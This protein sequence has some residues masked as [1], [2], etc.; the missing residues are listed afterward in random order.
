MNHN[1]KQHNLNHCHR[2]QGRQ[3]MEPSEQQQ[4]Q[5]ASASSSATGALPLSQDMVIDRLRAMLYQESKGYEYETYFPDPSLHHH[6]QQQQQQWNP[7]NQEWR[8]KICQWTYNVVDTYD[9]PREIVAL[10]LNYF[11]RFLATRGNQ[12]NGTLALLVSLTTLHIAMKVHS[13]T[14]TFKLQKLAELSR[15]Q[16]GPRHI[17]QMEWQIMSALKFKLHPPTLFAF[18]SYYMMLFPQQ[19]QQQ[20]QQDFYHHHPYE[21][22]VIPRHAVRKELFEVAIYMAELSV[23][24]SFFV[25]YPTSLVA[26]AALANVMEDMPPSKLPPSCKQGFWDLVSVNVGLEQHP[27]YGRSHGRT[28]LLQEARDQLRRMF[29]PTTTA[30][31]SSGQPLASPQN[32]HANGHGNSSIHST[33]SLTSSPTSAAEMMAM[34]DW[35]DP[36]QYP[37]HHHTAS[38]AMDCGRDDHRMMSV[39]HPDTEDEEDEGAS[40]RYSPS[41]PMSNSS[42]PLTHHHGFKYHHHHQQQQQQAAIHHAHQYHHQNQ[43]RSTSAV[44][45][46]K[47]HHHHHQQ[48]H[49]Q[50]YR[51]TTNSSSPTSFLAR[52]TSPA[53]RARMACSPIVAG[54][55]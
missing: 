10:S 6:H 4:P 31:A 2:G 41:P 16:F 15:G 19:Q 28:K 30:A 38:S 48:H 1:N 51:R 50:K 42:E 11:D 54:V 29:Q 24:D 22:D 44:S 9:L 5:D 39:H 53:S 17:E 26:L 3:M 27:H 32:G 12:C 13:S 20:Q 23:C 46:S 34:E 52:S 35:N 37:N 25:P 47:H 14:G 40:F 43:G 36:V 55:Q 33:T 8:E 18:V 45:S 7:L 49:Q 21:A